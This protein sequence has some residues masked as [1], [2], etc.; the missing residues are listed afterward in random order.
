MATDT[1][2]PEESTVSAI[3]STRTVTLAWPYSDTVETG[4]TLADAETAF[5]SFAA[6]CR[7][8]GAP[9]ETR[10]AITNFASA[11]GLYAIWEETEPAVL[12]R[13]GNGA[14]CDCD[15]PQTP[16]EPLSTIRVQPIRGDLDLTL[17]TVTTTT[18]PDQAVTV[19]VD[20]YADRLYGLVMRAGNR[21]DALNAGSV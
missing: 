14:I 13:D 11:P 19:D 10:V 3:T 5:G 17:G 4:F 6:R 21:R 15:A 2:T 7:A 16:S 20:L 9:D 12:H 18:D 8:A 1:T